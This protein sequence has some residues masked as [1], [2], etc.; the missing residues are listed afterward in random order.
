M[1]E[2]NEKNEQFVNPSAFSPIHDPAG[3]PI[4]HSGLGIA[5]FVLSMISIVSFV[6]LTIVIFSLITSA[7]DFTAIVDENNNRLMT[8]EE[9]IDKIG[10]YVGY[11]VLYPLLL[12]IVLIGL[13]LGL[14]AL[15]KPGYK[16]VFAVLGTIFN[17]LPLLFIVILMI[18]GFA[19]V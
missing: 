2:H 11:L 6:I 14:V 1:N 10:P 3:S 5:S 18:I 7:I 9:I 12:I 16:K 8:D 13:I 17:G 4:K 19:S 15:A